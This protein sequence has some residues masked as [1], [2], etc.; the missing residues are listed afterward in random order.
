MKYFR[1]KL[2][3]I[4][5]YTAMTTLVAIG[6][7]YSCSNSKKESSNS[8]ESVSQKLPNVVF[9]NADDLGYSDLSSYGATKVH[10]PNI[11]K[12]AQQGIRFTDAHSGSAVCTPSR[13]ALLTG[14]YPFRAG[15]DFIF[16]PV[17]LRD[18]LVINTDQLTLADVMKNAGYATACIGKWHLG[19]GTERPTDWNALLKPGPLELGFDY[20]F[21]L[22]VVNSHP[23]F[24]Y[25]EN[26]KILGADSN[27]PFVYD[28]V[29]K[30]KTYNGKYKHDWIGGADKAH[31]LY[32]DEKVGT[33]LKDKAIEWMKSQKDHPFF[34]YLATTNIHHP[35]TP[36]PQFKGTS[37]AGIYG[38]FIHELD[39]MVGEVLNTLKELGLEDNT[40]VVFT[41]DNGGML[42]LEGQEAWR[43]GHHQNGDYLGF[44][45]DAWEGGHRIPFIAKWPGKIKPNTT[46]N[47]LISNVDMLATFAA[48]TDQDLGA[49]DGV[50]S[51]NI[52][53]ALLDN[54]KDQ[55]RNELVIHPRWSTHLSVRKG[56]WMYISA[57]GHGGFTGKK[58]GSHSLGGASA[59]LLTNQVNSD[60]DQ[61]KIKTDAPA[62]QLYNLEE[63][64]Y[65][66]QNLASKF[67]KVVKEMEALLASMKQSNKTRP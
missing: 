5:L 60:V 36:A 17:M 41:S 27:D 4:N 29:A 65:E 42:N 15:D 18:S 34:L 25:V 59:H 43:L 37:E 9:I 47:Q 49:N 46:S 21:G 48:I 45:F 10:T 57:Q 67:P 24:V 28:A 3:K 44:K 55:I 8:G 63:D 6:I 52:L 2:T 35:F 1:T 11:D 19:F 38:D 61:G 32:E 64:P 30:T 58:I 33:V 14:Q 66:T 53:P 16:G 62:V 26:Y 13:Y 40:I 23:P 12:I 31:A 22:P 7:L 39:W 54:S 56:K 50:D 51:Y 20:Y